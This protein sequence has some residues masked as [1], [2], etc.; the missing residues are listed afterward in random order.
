MKQFDLR[1]CS[2]NGTP[3]PV[4]ITS[5]KTRVRDGLAR[6]TSVSW[7]GGAVSTQGLVGVGHQIHD[8]LMQLVGIGP[9][10]REVV[11]PGTLDIHIIHL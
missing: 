7:R 8:D 9:E 4:S 1:S 11:R 3:G 2:S 6:V 5:R 10:R